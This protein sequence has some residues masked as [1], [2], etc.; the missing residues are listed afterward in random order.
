MIFYLK[1]E[2]FLNMQNISL[3]KLKKVHFIGIGGISMSALAE[4]LIEKNIQVSG[5]DAKASELT[6]RLSDSGAKILYGQKSENITP[7][8]DL[9][10]YTAAI[11]KDNPEFMAAQHDGACGLPRTDYEGIQQCH[12]CCRNTR[13]NHHHIHDF[14]YPACR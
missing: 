7:D 3:N 4:I 12:Q 1:M 2:G 6:N 5:S 9:V 8:I 14:P 11:H 10:V 13:K